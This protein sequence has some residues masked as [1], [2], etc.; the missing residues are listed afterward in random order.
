MHG[1]ANSRGGRRAG[2][3]PITDI[4]PSVIS[5]KGS[6]LFASPSAPY[7]RGGTGNETSP[8]S[9]SA[10]G[11]GRCRAAILIAIHLGA[12]V[13]VAAAALDHRIS[14]RWRCRHRGSDHG[15]VVVGAAR[16]TDHHREPARRQH[17]YC[18]PSSDQ[19]AARRVHV[20][21]SRAFHRGQRKSVREPSIRLAAGYRAGFRAHRLSHGDGRAPIGTGKDYC[22]DHRSRQGKSG[23]GQ[24]GLVWNRL[25]VS[26]GRR[27]VQDHGWRRHGARPVSRRCAND[28]RS[29][30][31]AGA[32]WNRCDDD[33]A[34][35]HPHWHTAG[36]R[37]GGHQAI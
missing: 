11:R 13:S 5:G 35:A 8:P 20:A 19:F 23:Q 4:A 25:G 21:V 32:G 27:A 26:P 14:A 33:I 28:A 7:C 10:T 29:G 36:T 9:I 31:G 1:F 12:S 22:R 30:R 15:T 6:R 2:L 3:V 18:R 17:Q 37:R 34:T 16:S 24:H